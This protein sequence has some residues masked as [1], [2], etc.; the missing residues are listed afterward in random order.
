MFLGPNEPFRWERS[1][2][3]FAPPVPAEEGL[4]ACN[5]SDLL[6]DLAM[7]QTILVLSDLVGTLFS[8]PQIPMLGLQA[9]VFR[10]VGVIQVEMEGNPFYEACERQA[11]ICAREAPYLQLLCTCM[12]LVFAAIVPPLAIACAVAGG[13]FAGLT[14]RAVAR[15]AHLRSPLSV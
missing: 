13:I 1:A 10:V 3:S 14:V 4:F 2:G 15:S 12:V 9:L 6:P 5:L 11:L 7:M 8:C